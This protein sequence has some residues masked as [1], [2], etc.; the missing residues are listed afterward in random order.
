MEGRICEG[1]EGGVEDC[2]IGWGGRFEYS[3][4]ERPGHFVYCT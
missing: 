3:K 2:G 1:E 4:G